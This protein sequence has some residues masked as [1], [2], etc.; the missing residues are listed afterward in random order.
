MALY[1]V[2][3]AESFAFL[4]GVGALFTACVCGVLV[5]WACFVCRFVRDGGGR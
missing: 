1:L 2:E 5:V 3:L 4:G